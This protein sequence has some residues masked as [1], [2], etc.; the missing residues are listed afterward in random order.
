MKK[1]PTTNIAD[2][3][4]ILV[5]KAANGGNQWYTKNPKM[6]LQKEEE[7]TVKTIQQ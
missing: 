4:L 7:P 1:G 6:A 2:I 5:H 3:T